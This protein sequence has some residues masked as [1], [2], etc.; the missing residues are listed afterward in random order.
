[1][2]TSNQRFKWYWLRPQ[3]MNKKLKIFNVF[4]YFTLKFG[5]NFLEATDTY[6]KRNSACLLYR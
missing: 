6:I 5:C 3:R 4:Q 2:G 1:M